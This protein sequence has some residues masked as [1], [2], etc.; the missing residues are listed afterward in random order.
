[1]AIPGRLQFG[2]PAAQGTTRLNVTG[3][4]DF[5]GGTVDV[6]DLGMTSGSY[7]LATWTGSLTGVPSLGLRP[8]GMQLSLVVDA[9][10]RQLRLEAVVFPPVNISAFSIV[11]GVGPNAGMDVVTLSGLS[12]SGAG[13]VIESSSDLT[14]WT[15]VSP[16]LSH[17]SG[18]LSFQFTQPANFQRRYFRFQPQ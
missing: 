2:L 12:Y 16:L 6:S 8:P 1:M 14:N 17:P 7:V 11:P 10:A 9:V 3:N 13:Y 4:A 15:P 18:T 5:T